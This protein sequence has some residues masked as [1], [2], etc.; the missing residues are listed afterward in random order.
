M[1][2]KESHFGALAKIEIGGKNLRNTVLRAGLAAMAM[3]GMALVVAAQGPPPPRGGFGRGPGRG[4]PNAGSFAFGGLVGG[5]GGKVVT[6]KP[7]QATFTI[8]RVETLPNNTITNT[9]TG[10]LARDADG[11]TYRDVK[12]PAI[13]PLASSGKAQEFAYIRNVSK[14]IEY[15]VNVTK[16]NYRAFAMRTG[17]PRPGARARRNAGGRNG[18][19]SRNPG[20]TESQSTYTDPATHKVYKV[21]VRKVVRTIPAGQIGNKLPI[22][23][24]SERL[25]SPDLDVVL[26]ETHSDPRFGTSTY[27]LTNFG[28]PAASLFTPNPSFQQVQGRRSGFDRPRRG[29]NQPPPPP[30]Q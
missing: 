5:F 26:Q 17:N 7:F 9:T 19:G 12:L 1:I 14:A 3:A 11:S 20:V 10:T 21:N 25:Y 22:V 27:Q 28:Q 4:G 13:G 8:T 30:Q 29:K 16:G 23:I 2:L 18:A 24:T 6:G 15:I